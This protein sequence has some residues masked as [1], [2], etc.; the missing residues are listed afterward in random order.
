MDDEIQTDD[1]GPICHWC[2]CEIYPPDGE[3][4]CGCC[5]IHDELDC[6]CGE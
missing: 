5:S 1:E 4:G 3:C 6:T 2:G